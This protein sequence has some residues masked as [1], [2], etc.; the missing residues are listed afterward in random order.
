V[1]AWDEHGY[2]VRIAVL[3][4]D[5]DELSALRAQV[6][7]R[8]TANGDGTDIARGLDRMYGYLI[9]DRLYVMRRA[10]ALVACH[11]LTPHGDPAFWARDEL[12]AEALYLDNAMVR[13]SSAH[14]GIGTLITAHALSEAR[15]R[16]IPL[17]RLDC[18]RVPALRDHWE[19][20]GFTHLRDAVVPGRASGTLME[21]KI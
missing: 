16:G 1:S 19:S 5:W 4:R 8:L 21:M 12:A 14:Q 18:Q 11:A 9:D 7:R 3:E 13:P 2:S 20:L 6:E 10:G 17:L 15:E